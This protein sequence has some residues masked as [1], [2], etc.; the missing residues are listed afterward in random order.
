MDQDHQNIRTLF[1]GG[2]VRLPRGIGSPVGGPPDSLYPKCRGFIFRG[3][4]PKAFLRVFL[5]SAKGTFP[6]SVVRTASIAT[7]RSG[8]SRS[9]RISRSSAVSVFRSFPFFS[10]F[11]RTRFRVRVRYRT[12]LPAAIPFLSRPP[13]AFDAFDGRFVR[14]ARPT[15]PVPFALQEEGSK[16]QHVTRISIALN[17]GA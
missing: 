9:S 2:T 13:F 3:P 8:V 15:I 4:F 16:R 14:F 11:A 12:P 1:H 10:P 6:I 5:Q 7:R 17:G